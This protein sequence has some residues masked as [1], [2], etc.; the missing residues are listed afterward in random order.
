MKKINKLG[1]VTLGVVAIISASACSNNTSN[2]AEIVQNNNEATGV[3]QNN[4][5]A[6]GIEQQ[7]EGS[8]GFLWKVENK[9]N[10][11]YLLGTM[12]VVDKTIYPL[13]PEIEDA[14][15]AADYLGVEID[16]TKV[17]PDEL[18]KLLT[19]VGNYNDGTTLKDHISAETYNKVTAF[20]KEN[21]LPENSYDNYKAWYAS[22]QMGNIIAAK[23]E[24][25]EVMGVDMYFMGKATNEKKPVIGLETF[26]SQYEVFNNFS[27]SLQETLILQMLDPDSLPSST[28]EMAMDDILKLWKTGDEKALLE[29]VDTLHWNDEYFKGMQ[30]DRNVEMAEKIQGYL[31]SDKK[32]T[33]MIAIGASHYVGDSSVVTMLEKQGFKVVKQ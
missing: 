7:S 3:V 16:F 15:N 1:L 19:D 24:L 29:F 12:H 2:N 17:V 13:R 4:N 23:E 6:T 10:T 32:E 28:A 22:Q 21:G 9:G 5:E 30:T 8:K 26:E 14:F 31:N 25:S 27:D 20:L 18:A 11:V 33:Y